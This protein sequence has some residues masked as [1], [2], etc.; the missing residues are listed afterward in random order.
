M[1]E[2]TEEAYSPAEKPNTLLERFC[3]EC[4]HID[5]EAITGE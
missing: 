3:I 4:P 2:P 5:Y 1:N